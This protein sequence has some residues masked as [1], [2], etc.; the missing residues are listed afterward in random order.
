MKINLLIIFG[1]FSPEHS[2]SVVSAKSIYS[3]LDKVKYNPIL[4]GISNSGKWGIFSEE[5]FKSLEIVPERNEE[6]SLSLNK[7]KGLLKNGEFIPI[8][9]AFPILHG[10]GGEDGIIQGL[11]EISKIPYV[12]S[13]VQSSSLC[14]NKVLTKN[15][16]KAYNIEGPKFISFTKEGIK[17]INIEE[18]IT[19]RINFPFFVKPSNAGSSIGIT[20]VKKR[21]FLKNAIEIAFNYSREIIIEEA[22]NAREIECSVIGD[23]EDVQASLPGEIVTNRE[24]YDF[25]AKYVDSSSKL[26]I[27][28]NLDSK[29]IDEIKTL[30]IKCFKALGCYGMARV[31]F[32]LDKNSEEILFNEVNTI[33]GFTS[34]SMYPKLLEYSG[35]PFD[36]IIDKLIEL[37]FL[38]SKNNINRRVLENGN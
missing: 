24:F 30:S 35:I 8:D 23:Y 9:C 6:L 26:I 20:K 7:H 1:G 12:G 11:L 19:G 14:M 13:D 10:F 16:L 33:P 38:R 5:E 31:D 27:P 18:E 15:V 34:I 37:A 32:L 21:E 25:E 28:S 4:L 36:K 22:I 2:I 3:N 29:K 17:S